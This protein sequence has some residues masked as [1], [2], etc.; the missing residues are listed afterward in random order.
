MV[1]LWFP[2][3]HKGD[4]IKANGHR[5]GDAT[6]SMKLLFPFFIGSFLMELKESAPWNKHSFL[7][8]QNSIQKLGVWRHLVDFL[9]F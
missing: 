2:N 1:F 7:Y 5:L 6:L 9:P 8:K 3:P 4:T